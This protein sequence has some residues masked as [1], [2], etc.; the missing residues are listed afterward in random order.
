MDVWFCKY[1]QTIVYNRY[2]IDIT[3]DISHTLG[4]PAGQAA[5]SHVKRYLHGI[6]KMAPY[7]ALRYNK[8]I[9]KWGGGPN[10]ERNYNETGA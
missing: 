6:H 10:R 1:G 4:R 3:I 2:S 7:G 5:A 8:D 9:I